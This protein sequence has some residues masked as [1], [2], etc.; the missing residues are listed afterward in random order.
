MADI[1][2][3]CV[4]INGE[5]SLG[6]TLLLRRFKSIIADELK[7]KRGV[8]IQP[9]KKRTP[10]K[11]TP[12]VAQYRPILGK[13]STISKGYGKGKTTLRKRPRCA[14]CVTLKR[15]HRLYRLGFPYLW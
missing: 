11:A 10:G 8:G 1:L 14:N 5:R 12:K 6:R 15:Q 9:K 13:N 2:L 4:L 3:R 7:R